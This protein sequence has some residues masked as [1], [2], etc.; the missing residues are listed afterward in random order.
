MLYK[1]N[2]V[3]E[4]KREFVPDIKKEVVAFANTE[5]GTIYVGIDDNGEI[6]GVE[7]SGKVLMQIM[8]MLRD[9]IKPDITMFTTCK[10]VK[11]QNKEFIEIDVQRGTNTP[12]Y[13]ADKG[14][15][16]AGVYVRQGTSS[17]P[18]SENAIRQMIKETD[19]DKYEAIRSFNQELTF[20]ASYNEFKKR[21]FEL[22]EAQMKTLGLINKDNMYTNLGLLLSD[23]CLHTIKV[24]VFNGLSKSEFKDRREFGSSLLKQITIAYEFIDL[25]N[26][27]RSEFEGLDRIDYRDYPEEALREALLNSL[28]HRDY[29]FSGSTLI[30]IYDDRIEFVSI[31]GLVK[32]IS[33]NDIMLGIS[34]TRNEKLAA[35]FYRLKLIEAYG[36]GIIKIMNSYASSS[37]KPELKV[38]D[39]AFL[40][41]LPNLNFK[42]DSHFEKNHE[43][44]ILE[45]LKFH[46][47]I[48]RKETEKL[49]NVKQTMAGKVLREMVD[50]GQLKIEGKAANTKYLLA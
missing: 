39:N 38:S 10:I 48:N 42:R 21:G 3:I 18:A 8:N 7:N 28:V 29:S 15:R 5:G 40:I 47:S 14:I 27:T 13:I 34:Q 35:V 49:L 33:I 26:K 44:S 6:V 24:A 36:T 22:G 11:D 17:A 12:Y 4:L 32:G 9:S 30:N 16:P 31:G 43:D 46:N 50:K 20:E 2:H 1:E 41:S 25:L 23:Q 37:Q 45:Y 19:G